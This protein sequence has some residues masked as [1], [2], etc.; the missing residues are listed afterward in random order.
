MTD[1]DIQIELERIGFKFQKVLSMSD[2]N[3]ET[4][5]F[6]DDHIC[7]VCGMCLGNLTPY[8]IAKE[9]LSCVEYQIKQ[10]IE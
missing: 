6:N 5:N 4:H 2:E 3:Y 7:K 10:I 9:N 1:N 8:W